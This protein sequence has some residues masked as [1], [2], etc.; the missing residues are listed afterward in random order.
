MAGA[1]LSRSMGGVMKRLT[2]KRLRTKTQS[3][4]GG[5]KKRSVGAV[6]AGTD[7]ASN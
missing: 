3:S 6:G 1:F 7:T 2:I 5:G 4:C